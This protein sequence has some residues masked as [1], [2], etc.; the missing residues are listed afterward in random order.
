MKILL[1]LYH[2]KIPLVVILSFSELPHQHL[3]ALFPSPFPVKVPAWAQLSSLP[4]TA[5]LGFPLFHVHVLDSAAES[6]S[7]ARNLFRTSLHAKYLSQVAAAWVAFWPSI[8][9]H[10]SIFVLLCFFNCKM[11]KGWFLLDVSKLLIFDS[12]TW[13][14]TIWLSAVVLL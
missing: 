9:E 1:C 12:D 6:F 2:A 8:F 7:C 13:R 11:L 14:C 3:L 10:F 4:L 5:Y